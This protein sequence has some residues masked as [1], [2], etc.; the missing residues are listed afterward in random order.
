MWTNTLGIDACAALDGLPGEGS[1]LWLG[2]IR[3]RKR[4]GRNS[5]GGD[6]AEFPGGIDRGMDR[7]RADI[8]CARVYGGYQS[9]GVPG[10]CGAGAFDWTEIAAGEWR[11]R[12]CGAG[13]DYLERARGA[14]GLGVGGGIGEWG[15]GFLGGGVL[16]GRYQ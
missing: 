2:Q 4:R 10:D 9:E 15:G 13:T 6:P 8:V 14:E 12:K 7:K 5:S 1:S 3:W 16:V 11:E